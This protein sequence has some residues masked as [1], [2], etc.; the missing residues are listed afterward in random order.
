M[1]VLDAIQ[2]RKSVRGFKPDPI[3]KEIL[4]KVLALGT[5]S[6]SAENGQ[7]WEITVVT[8]EALDNIRRENICKLNAKELFDPEVQM[9]IHAGV[10][11][12][13]HMVLAAQLYGLMDIAREDMEKRIAWVQRGF[14]FYDAPAA[15]ILTSSGSLDES[16]TQFDLGC[17]TQTICLAALGYGLGTCITGQG[18][19]YPEVA[20]KFCGIPD[21][22]RIVMA[23]AIGYPDTEFPANALESIREPL[24]NITTWLGFD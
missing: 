13:R 1:D 21:S 16:P 23:I 19:L 7:P 18:V 10:Y 8:G 3:S 20:R 4:Q 15:I 6:P 17:L 24:E 2:E 11:K 12:Q 9:H 22:E 5:R 14:R